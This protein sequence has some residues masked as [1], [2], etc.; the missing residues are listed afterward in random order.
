[1][2]TILIENKSGKVKLNEVVTRE[3]I[4]RMIDEIG[5]LFGASA[6][7]QGAD[8]G[9]IMNVAEN[10]VDVLDIEINSPGGSVFDGYTIYQE[11]KSLRDRG[12]VVNA[13]ITGM[14]A[15]MASVICMACDK[16]TIVPHGR[17]M[18]HDASSM[19][20]GNAEQLRKTAS[21]LD[22]I[23]ADIA[24]IYA[25]KTGIDSEEIRKMMKRET[26]MNASETVAKGFADEL[27]TDAPV[28]IPAKAVTTNTMGLFTKP[29]TDKQD[30]I[31]ALE[32]ENADLREQFTAL[33]ITATEN[34]EQVVALKADLVSVAAEC[35]QLTADLATA[36]ATIAD[37]DQTITAANEK[38]A[39]F[40]QEVAA[41]TLNQV[42]SIGFKGEIPEASGD[43][44]LSNEKT[45]AEF[46]ALSPH[47]R[48]SFVKAGGKIK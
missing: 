17:M 39:S 11:I 41:Q 31:T 47:D 23:S 22:G 46:N 18:I 40:D 25:A 19:A 14:A 43:V 27:V 15:S 10:A 28:E 37:Q 9:E 24:N 2:K 13:T 12:V 44:G 30:A 29:D 1:M 34:A 38:L 4:G 21:L 6:V 36:T 32:A 8:F 5:R 33:Q 48:M 16:V 7:A 26:W 20:S 42:A 3:S 45:L 35:Q